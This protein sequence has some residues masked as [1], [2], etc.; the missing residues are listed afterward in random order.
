MIVFFYEKHAAKSPDPAQP[1]LGLDVHVL[2]GV[3]RPCG[4][5]GTC[6]RVRTTADGRIGSSLC[7]VGVH[8]LRC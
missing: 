8:S 4:P 2:W 6:E 1:L 5:D 7:C 3:L